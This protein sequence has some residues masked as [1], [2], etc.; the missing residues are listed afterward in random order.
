MVLAVA[1]DCLAIQCLRHVPVFT[2]KR[3]V[4]KFLQILR[5]HSRHI[6]HTLHHILPLRPPRRPRPAPDPTGTAGGAV[7]LRLPLFTRAIVFTAIE[8]G[9]TARLYPGK[10][11][12]DLVL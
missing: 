10:D 1:V 6:P 8:D 2:A 11:G 4:G 5:R 3:R 12:V 9:D 7:G